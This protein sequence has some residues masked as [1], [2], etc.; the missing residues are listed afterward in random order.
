MRIGTTTNLPF[1]LFEEDYARAFAFIAEAGFED[2]DY[3]LFTPAQMAL[4]DSLDFFEVEK[5]YTE[6]GRILREAGLGISQTHTPFPTNSQDPEKHAHIIELQIKSIIA[7]AALGCK[8][9]VI[10]PNHIPGCI[11]G[12]LLPE[13]KKMNMIFYSSLLPAL[14]EYDVSCAIENMFGR[15]PGTKKICPSRCSTAEEINDYITSLNSERFV[16]CLDTGHAN[17]TGDTPANMAKIL[18]SNLKVL[19]VHDNDGIEDRHTMPYTGTIDWSSFGEA[20]REIGFDGTVSLEADETFLM[21][22]FMALAPDTARFMAASA[23]K[24]ADLAK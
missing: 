3:N 18:G 17:L 1:K 11:N 5:K 10:H 24:I 12:A 23:R 15:D 4:M 19:H 9:A 2:V 7:T 22:R 20:L 21:N 6:I 13:A 8:Y 14:K 16:A